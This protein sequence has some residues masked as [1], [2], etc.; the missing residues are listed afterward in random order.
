MSKNCQKLDIFLKKKFFFFFKFAISNFFFEKNEKFWQFFK[1]K[2]QVLSNYL[3]VKWQFSGGSGLEPTF[4]QIVDNR[5][6]ILNVLRSVKTG[7][8]QSRHLSHLAP[9]LSNV[10]TNLT[11]GVLGFCFRCRNKHT[12]LQV[13][14]CLCR[15]S[16]N[17][18]NR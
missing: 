6:Q 12:V 3:T 8:K 4:G 2:C 13:W 7:R 11:S 18:T 15:C 10:P 14:R 5:T 1:T 16:L 9:F 17:S